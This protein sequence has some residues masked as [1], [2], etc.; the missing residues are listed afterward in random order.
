MVKTKV[1]ATELVW[2]FQQ[3]IRDY[4]D[5]PMG[6]DVAIVSSG[7]GWTVATNARQ[8]RK[9]PLCAKRIDK[10]QRELREVYALTRD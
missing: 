8:R 7:D 10:L 4:G 1:S 3:R 6:T 5:C 9:Y 2:I